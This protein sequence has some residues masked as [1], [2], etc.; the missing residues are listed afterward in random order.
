MRKLL[1]TGAFNYSQKQLNDLGHL[2]YKVIFV[3]DERE[4]LNIDVSE[5]DAVVCN[6]LFIYNDIKKFKSLKAIQLTSV[7]L[8]R[9]PLDYINE[10][11]IQLFNAKDVYSIPM[12]EWAILKTLEIYK[13]SRVFYGNQIQHKWEKQRD[14]FELTGKKATIIG[15]GSVGKELAKRFKAFGVHIISV[16]R[17]VKTDEY[18]DESFLIKDVDAALKKSDIIVLSLPLVDETKHL[19]NETRINSMKDNALLINVSRGGIID[20]RVLIKSLKKNKFLGVALDVFEEEPL[21]KSPLWDFENV[22]VT[23]HNSFISDQVKDRLFRQIKL[24]LK[25]RF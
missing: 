16:D 24:F 7:G 9:V 21:K 2:G 10:K 4:P 5:I 19:I 11:G 22:I 13:K 23:P 1:L 17:K 20:E 15:Y 6:S 8:D 25:Q 18:T 3:Q 14:L 12:A